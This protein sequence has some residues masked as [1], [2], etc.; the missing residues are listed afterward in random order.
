[1]SADFQGQEVQFVFNDSMEELVLP[2][3]NKSIDLEQAQDFTKVHFEGIAKPGEIPVHVRQQWEKAGLV[4]SDQI[5]FLDFRK[6]EN[7]KI[8][9]EP[10]PTYIWAFYASL[11]FTLLLVVWCEGGKLL[12]KLKKK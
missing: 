3:K 2:A 1:M 4:L 12:E 10:D 8:A 11:I 7:G 9:G 5:Y 6:L